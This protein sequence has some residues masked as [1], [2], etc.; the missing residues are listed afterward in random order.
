MKT[1][2]FLFALILIFQSP[3]YTNDIAD[4][5]ESVSAQKA[6]QE[7]AVAQQCAQPGSD[8]SSP[9]SSPLDAPNG[10]ND[11]I[12]QMSQEANAGMS[13][14]VQEAAETVTSDVQQSI[15]TRRTA[16]TDRP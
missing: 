14:E 10:G 11:P 9:N 3:A 6:S 12:S 4:A 5:T 7:A 13:L 16:P 1:L 8:P 2:G 15:D